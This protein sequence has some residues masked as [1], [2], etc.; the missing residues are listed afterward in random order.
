LKG[1]GVTLHPITEPD[2]MLSFDN[3]T[4]GMCLM[5]Y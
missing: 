4:R 3:D 2:E 5:Q 1:N